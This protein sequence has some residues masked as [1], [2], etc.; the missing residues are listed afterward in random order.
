MKTL[1]LNSGDFNFWKNN[2]NSE[3]FYINSY[4]EE[5]PLRYPCVVIYN[6][7]E[8]HDGIKN[9]IDYEFVYLNDFDI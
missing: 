4:A 6:E 7:H 9:N 8:N 3:S 5:R 2:Y 1:I